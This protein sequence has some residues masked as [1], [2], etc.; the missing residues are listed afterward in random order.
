MTWHPRPECDTRAVRPLLLLD[1]DGVLMPTGRSVPPGYERRTAGGAEI[2]I[3]RQ[4]GEWLI[5]LARS[6]ELVWASTWGAK[7]NES[8]GTVLGLPRLESIV[9]GDLP[10]DGTRKLKAVDAFAGERALAWV[11]DEIYDDA[12]TWATKR[13]ASTLLVRTSGSV[14]L[15]QTHIDQ[16]KRFAAELGSAST[17]S[18]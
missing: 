5:D 9:L 3:C 17:P 4:H 13:S 16:L 2:V 7:A 12:T 8:F 6:F 1:V 10:R 15:R 14:G 18:T 11:D